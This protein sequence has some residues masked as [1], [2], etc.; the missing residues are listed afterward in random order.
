M[1]TILAKPAFT[2][3]M[4]VKGG[5]RDSMNPR[6]KARAVNMP[7]SAM[8]LIFI[9]D[10]FMWEAFRDGSDTSDRVF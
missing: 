10:L 2:P 9:P 8:R 3:G 7:R 1:V 4:P 5:I 6:T